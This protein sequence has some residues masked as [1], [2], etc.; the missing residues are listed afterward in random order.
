MHV[1]KRFIIVD[2]DFDFEEKIEEFILKT[3]GELALRN[4]DIEVDYG[5]YEYNNG[6]LVD[7]L[8]LEIIFKQ[9]KYLNGKNE[10]CTESILLGFEHKGS[11][12]FYIDGKF[13]ALDV[14]EWCF[15]GLIQKNNKIYGIDKDFIYN[16]FNDFIMTC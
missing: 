4:I 8:R 7:E 12:P 10:E 16:S 6:L 13:V 3:F 5:T 9:Y 11:Q 2:E 1:D 14:Y 15:G